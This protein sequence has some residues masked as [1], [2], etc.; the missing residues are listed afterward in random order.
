MLCPLLAQSERRADRKNDRFD[1]KRT[2][3]TLLM[4]IDGVQRYRSKLERVSG[5]GLEMKFARMLSLLLAAT[6]LTVP[7]IAHA[8]EGYVLAST[9]ASNSE[10]W[11]HRPTIRKISPTVARAW[12]L[13][14]YGQKMGSEGI[15]SHRA[16]MEFDCA[17]GRSRE[18]ETTYYAAKWAQIPKNSFSSSD[19]LWSSAP[20]NSS[21]EQV[22]QT[23]CTIAGIK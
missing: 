7:A 14:N 18:I 4:G 8:P 23:V 17:Q 2:R 11:V 9:T 3:D 5:A 15:L 13:V 1:S 20:P 19:E 10:L 12:V 16:D 21:I 22:L 6:A